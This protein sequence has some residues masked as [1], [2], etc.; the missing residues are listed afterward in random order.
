M[1]T[2]PSADDH[3]AVYIIM[4]TLFGAEW[5][6]QK[7]TK[8]FTDVFTFASELKA[9]TIK[10]IRSGNWA[11]LDILNDV[12]RIAES[13]KNGLL[14]ASSPKGCP[15]QYTNSANANVFQKYLPTFLQAIGLNPDSIQSFETLRGS[16]E[17]SMRRVEVYGNGGIPVHK[18]KNA[19]AKLETVIVD[20]LQAA[21]KIFF[22]CIGNTSP[23]T[24]FVADML[25]AGDDQ[26][27][28]RLATINTGLDNILRLPLL[29]IGISLV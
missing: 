6:K 16:V 5:A 14:I 3:L 8:A 11:Q 12:I 7:G 20:Y 17:E 13:C 26:F 25:Y 21:G 1:S 22:N 15:G 10:K 23:A 28:V 24:T 29:Y 19:K 4:F 2:S 27:T 9:S 18:C